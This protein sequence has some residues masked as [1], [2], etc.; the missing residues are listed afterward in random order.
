MKKITLSLLFFF[1]S[2]V[3]FSQGLPLEGFES[4]GGPDLPFPTTP[5]E[6]TLGTSVPG[7]TWQVFDNNV[8]LNQRWDVINGAGNFYAGANATF[9]DRENINAGNTSED[10][11][12]TP[13]ITIPVNGQL[14]FWTRTGANGDANTI[15][16]IKVAPATATQIN[17][18]AYSI[19]QQ[20]S[21]TTLHITAPS[22]TPTN[23]DLYIQKTVDLTAYAG[24]QVY[25]AF[26]R[27]FTQPTAAI[28]GDRWY[29][30]DVQVIQQCFNPTALT[31]SAVTFNSANLSWT[32]PGVTSWQIEVLPTTSTPTGVGVSYSGA[33]PYSATGLLPNT[34]YQYFVRSVC[35]PGNFSGWAGPFTFTTAVA[36]PICG[37][38]FIDSGGLTGNYANNSDLTTTICP[39]NP[40]DVVT[41]TFTSFNT[42]AT[43][44]GLYIFNGNSITA[45]LMSS[46][47]PAGTAPLTTPGAYWGTTNI[48]SFTSTAAN[49]CLT[50]RFQSNATTVAAGWVANV[51]CAPAPVCPQPNSL[52]TS[53]VT[54]NSVTLNW[55]E[56]GTAPQWNVIALPCGSPAPNASSTGFT[57]A[58]TNSNFVLNGLNGDTCYNIYVRSVCSAG[59]FSNW[60][61]PQTI[62]TQIAPPA[63]GGTYV[64]T[65]GATGNYANNADVTTTICPTNP[66]DVVTVTFT[67]FNTQA[68]FD[69]LYIYNGNSIAAPQISSGNPV[70]TAPLT[71]AGA[72]WGTTNIGSFTSTAANGCLTFRFRSNATTVAAGWVANVTCAPAPIC[73]QPNSLA[74]SV[75]TSNSVT[76]NWVETGTATSWNVI[77]VPCGS[78]APNASTTGFAVA[79]NNINYVLTGLNGDTCYDVYVRSSC[80]GGNFSTWAGPRTITTQIAPPACGGVYT[81]L[82]GVT[83]T[84]PANSDSTVTI[85]PI[86]PT[87]VVTVTFTSFTTE[88]NYDALYVFNG[89][90]IAAPQISS[91][92]LA[93][94][95]PGGVAGGFWG[96]ANPGPF[97]STA[98]NGCLTFRFRSDG[99]VN[100]A[101]WVANV[102]CAP[103]PTCP[104]PDTVVATSTTSIQTTLSWNSPNS[105]TQWQ[106][107]AL[108]CGSPAPTASS[109]GFVLANTNTGFVLNGLTPDTCYEIYVRAVCSPTDLSTWSSQ[110]PTVQTQQTPPV[111]GGIFTD[112]G[113]ANANYPNNADS[114][115]TICPTNPGDV[116]T[117]TFTSFDTEASWDALYVFDGNTIAAPQIASTNAAGFVPGGL[118]GGFWGT[119]IPGPFTSSA[120]NGCLTFRFRSDGSFNNP[121]WVANISCSPAPNCPKPTT[122]TA[123]SIT[124]TSA[125][126]GW[127]ELNPAVTQWEVY[128]LPVTAPAPTPTDVGQLV[129]TNPA[130]FTGLNPATQYKFYVRSICPSGGTSL[131][132]NAFNFTTLIINDNCDGAIFTPVN[133]SAVCNQ[134]VSGTLTGATPTLPAPIAPCVGTANDDVWF[135]FIATNPFL[136]V[137]LQNIVG[138]TTNLNFG[139]YSGQCGTLTQVFCSAANA[140]SG[141]PNGLIIGQTY[142]I[143]VY[144]NGTTAQTVNF[145]LCISTPASC[146]SAQTACQNLNYQNTTGIP[147]QGT[148][149]CLASSPNPTY[150]TIQVGAS[151]PINLLL[152]QSTQPTVNNVPGPPNLDVDY[153]AWGPFTSQAA[154]CVAIGNPVTLAPGIGVPVTQTTGCSFSAA[155]TE[156]LNIANAVVG[157][158]YVILITNFSNQAGFINLTQ[159]NFGAPGAGVYECC[160][161][162]YFSYTPI[163]YCK[164]P[165]ATNPIPVITTGSLAGTFSLHPSSATGLVFANTATGEVDLAASAPGNY[166]ILNT[167]AATQSCEQKQQT[168]SISIVLPLT[169]TIAYSAPKF[170]NNINSLQPVTQTGT[171]GGVYA[172]SPNGG[173]F[174]NTTTGSINP[175]LSS[176]GIYT[177]TYSIP[178]STACVTAAPS[179][180]VEILAFPNLV[181]P[182]PVVSC[183][184]YLLPALTVGNYYT[185]SGGVGT[186]LDITVPITTSQTIYIFAGN[187]S[188]PTCTAEVSFSVTINTATAQ[189]FANVNSCGSY[190][191][192]ALNANNSYFTGANGTGTQLFP[193]SVILSSQTIYV[194]AQDPATPTCTAETSFTVTINAGPTLAPI[195]NVSACGSYVLPVLSQGNY[196]T[197]TNGTGTALSAGD[198]IINSQTIFVF[199]NNPSNPICNAEVSFSVTINSITAQQMQ[200]VNACTSYT[201]PSL[202][203]NNNYYTG[204]NGT[205]TQLAAGQS[206]STSQTIYIYA[207]STTTPVC[208]D[209]SSFDVSISNIPMVDTL[210]NVTSCNSYVLPTLVNGNYFT[211][212]NGTGTPLAAGSTVTTSQTIYIYAA[213]PSNA[214]CN[215]QTSF[216]VTINSITAQQIAN[217]TACDSYILPTLNAN[218]AYYT[219]TNGTGTQINAG[220]SITTN[221]TIYIYAQ[222]G[223]T[224]NCTSE[225]SF[226]VTITATPVL[227]DF[228][229]V[230][231]CSSYTLPT[232]TTGNY[233]TGINGSGSQLAAGSAINAT[234]T[235]YVYTSNGTC[236]TQKQFQVTINS[237][238]SF[239]VEGSCQGNS[240]ILEAIPSSTSLNLSDYS[241]S[242]TNSSGD[243]LGTSSTV[244][245]AENG[246]YSVLITSNGTSCSANVPYTA[247]QTSCS[248]QKGISPNGDGLNDSLDLTGYGVKQ[249][250]IF[251]RY[252]TKVYS[253]VNYANEWFGQTDSGKD[254]PDGTYYYVIENNNGENKTGWIYVNRQN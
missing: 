158:Y 212:M 245:V 246:T 136:T 80:S 175:S 25:I 234:Q 35:S 190:T 13:L 26:V 87:D 5:S 178:G 105:A 211:G 228:V 53:V 44:D 194:F 152:T 138:T 86:N 168:Y 151:G 238:P 179:A 206:I 61:G 155:S 170:C 67:S 134:T 2:F 203:A 51:T 195:A 100:Q 18:N 133:S 14:K 90:S 150:Y 69:G 79:N 42:Q 96:T 82:G 164:T 112:L 12:A 239:T 114:T 19:V 20:W 94:N 23:F 251:N 144:S 71:T 60:S 33:L 129:S 78:P 156:T 224:T 132:S 240:F 157:Q 58:G 16:Q 77:A 141:I 216:V 254:L 74:T 143:R 199:V 204:T 62:T 176:P 119:A 120:T 103:P 191:L 1:L 230:S 196:F 149:G 186:P 137:S 187:P 93:A 40:G 207:Q 127:T 52:T 106:V 65:G 208:T 27:Q 56:T 225:S 209:Q 159:T 154:A 32:S 205:G 111:C 36:P 107:L 115:I 197:A 126:L 142:Y 202:D 7:N 113:G 221:Q 72:F 97:T 6:W 128:L 166:L 9:I 117:V 59:N 183:N 220:T 89:N 237:T 116:V 217:V 66:T 165:G 85:C 15:F 70:G 213:N 39:T 153:A 75:V 54:S 3:T 17:P 185:Q 169:A 241:Y 109:T 140:T 4:T 171:T 189:Q 219:G 243:V 162:A 244:A 253:K 64:D 130:L 57:V 37:G 180:T 110:P 174:I 24:Q 188:E 148:I 223:G 184:S 102:T 81:D 104:R 214:T 172:A 68:T 31:A 34:A 92:N 193:G 249:L 122:L 181:Q 73:P 84:Y 160:P 145:N 63:C 95:V 226:T 10:Y 121:G 29:I 236:S 124:T 163:S 98:A 49:G 201:L 99:S 41:V 198:V 28:G 235:V 83:G 232:L 167:V 101:G 22:T 231:A 139:V 76:L 147:N 250:S 38:N 229:D 125:L 46:G 182:S 123:T 192:G 91:G 131:L 47:N 21:E 45:P 30:D 248:I 200:N 11:L 50:F 88:T 233:F 8:G 43:F 252:G 218:N 146:V 247:N 173:L 215:A 108:P 227:A 222:T 55:V 177:V 48:G 242:W 135:Q 210:P 118:P 161:D